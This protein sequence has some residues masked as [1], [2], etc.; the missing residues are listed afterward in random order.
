MSEPYVGQVI[1]VGFNFAPVGW[2]ICDGSLLPISQY[3]TLFALIG[4]TYGGDG[5]TTFA[6][7]DLR[8][9][10]A[11][12]AGQGNGL[13]NYLLGQQSGVE[14]V[15]LLTGNMPSHTHIPM[16]AATNST[17]TPSTSVVLASSTAPVNIYASSANPV[18]LAP[19]VVSTA[20]GG[21]LPHDNMQPYLTVTYIISLY[22]IF[23][24]QS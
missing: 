10:V 19:G 5:Q 21:A 3:E 15:T 16:A 20:P 1:A 14:Q 18:A 22:G 6:V 8:G 13:S 23:P 2:Q 9:R 17:P 12:G 24:Q 7:P 4:T 11:V